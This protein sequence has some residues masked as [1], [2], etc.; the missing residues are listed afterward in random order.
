MQK[1]KTLERERW[2]YQKE[3]RIHNFCCSAQQ[4]FHWLMN[5]VM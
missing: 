5:H 3:E 2:V 1:K 4:D